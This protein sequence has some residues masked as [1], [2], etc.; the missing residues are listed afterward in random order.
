MR[1][2]LPELGQRLFGSTNAW[3]FLASD[4][5]QFAQLPFSCRLCNDY[6]RGCKCVQ[7]MPD[8]K[9]STSSE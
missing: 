8:G 6:A 9:F 4:R 1:I 7:L 5:S 2:V 3:N